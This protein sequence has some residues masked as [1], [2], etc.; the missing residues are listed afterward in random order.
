MRATEAPRCGFAVATSITIDVQ[1]PALH[2]H[3]DDRGHRIDPLDADL[4]QLLD[5]G[6]HCVQLALQMRNLG[7]SDRDPRQ[8]RDAANGGSVDGHR[9]LEYSALRRS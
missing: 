9:D 3:R 8:M 5:E 7:F 6:Q 1:Q 4:R 2:G